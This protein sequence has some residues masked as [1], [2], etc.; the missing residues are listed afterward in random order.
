M[1]LEHSHATGHLVPA[2][3]RAR[4]TRAYR[5]RLA[6]SALAARHVGIG[7]RGVPAPAALRRA[8]P[9]GLRYAGGAVPSAVRRGLP[10]GPWRDG[11]AAGYGRRQARPSCV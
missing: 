8:L 7:G 5:P 6:R 4:H 1:P 3:A 11:G 9:A 10:A 2:I